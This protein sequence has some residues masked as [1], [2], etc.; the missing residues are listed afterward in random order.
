MASLPQ[1]FNQQFFDGGVV[2]AGYYL[3]TYESGTTTPLITCQDEDELVT[4]TNPI[5]LDADGRC[6][7]RLLPQS[8][9]LALYTPGGIP[10]G[11]LVK[12]FD[13]V[14]AAISLLGQQLLAATDDD[15]ARV[16]IDAVGL[17]GDEEIDGIKTFT[18]SPIIPDATT[19]HQPASKGQLDAAVAGITG[20]VVGEF[21]EFAHAVAEPG[22]EVCDGAAISRITY[23]ALFAKIGILWGAGDGVTTFN[24][25]DRRGVFTRGLDLGR[26]IDVGRVLGTEQA[27]QLPSHKH[28]VDLQ[29]LNSAGITGSGKVGTGNE[30]PE[31]T[32]PA[33]DTGLT[34]GTN[35]ASELRPRNVAVHYRIYTGVV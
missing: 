1:Y 30:A 26:G 17:D 32:I 11:A 35:N 2:A 14:G 5:I 19:A 12:T 23:A 18:S 3:Y 10:T 20:R 7:M 9:T 4:N 25:P 27:E 29:P 15:A 8:Y 6:S 24:K 16:I 21:A 13:D 31:G 28:T 22:W 33:F 34:G